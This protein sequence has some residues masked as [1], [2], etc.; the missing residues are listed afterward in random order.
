MYLFLGHGNTGDGTHNSNELMKAQV[1][2]H[3]NSKCTDNF[4]AAGQIYQLESTQICA[5]GGNNDTC[6]GE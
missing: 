5:G 3:G 6:Q 4:L 2:L 1:E